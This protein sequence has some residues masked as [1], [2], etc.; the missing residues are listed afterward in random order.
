[1]NAKIT[2]LLYAVRTV[3][4]KEVII[5]FACYSAAKDFVRE[6]DKLEILESYFIGETLIDRIV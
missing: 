5:E 1:M 3:K 4:D 2:D 6:D